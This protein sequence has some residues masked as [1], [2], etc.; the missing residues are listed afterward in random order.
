MNDLTTSE[1][2][3][4]FQPPQASTREPL[5][6][7]GMGC[8]FPG[9]SASPARFWENLLAGKDCIV[10]VP[11][12]RWDV[13]RFYDSD[14]EKPGK[15]YVKS[16][17]FLAENIFEF[18]A[19]FFGVSPR[20]AA[21]MDPQQRV[22]MEVSW[23]AL[24]DAGID[25]QSLAGSE[26]GV[27][28]GGFMLDNKL[29]QLSPLNRHTI[30]AST[31]VGMTL[32]MLS[33]RISYLY[34]LRGPSMTIDTA[35]SASM[36]ALDQA[37]HS[38]WNGNSKLALV[39]GVNL[40]HRP[41]I[42]VGLCK[43]GFLAPDGR[44]KAFDA[45]ANGYGRGEGAGMVVLKPLADA[46]RDGDRIYALIRAT[47]CNQDGRTDGITVPNPESQKALIRKVSARAGVP[48]KNIHYFEAHGTGT[49]VGDPLEMSAIGDTI[50]REKPASA[51]CIVGSVK[52]NIGHLEAASGVAGLI[53]TS[54]CL[55]HRVVPP[56]ANLQQLNP[57]IPFQDLRIKVPRRP[58]PLPAGGKTIYGGINSFGYG[59]TN[60]CAIL[61]SY[62]PQPQSV[63]A[64]RIE[65]PAG[66]QYLLPLSARSK[67]A[68]TALVDRY[69]QL[70]ETVTPDISA[71]CYSAGERR[72]HLSHRVCVRGADLAEL[73]SGLRQFREGEPGDLYVEGQVNQARDRLVFVFTGMGPQWW[74]MGRELLA[75]EPVFRAAVERCDR[76]FRPIAGWS[77]LEEMLKPEAE[78]RIGET[79]IAQ[80]ANF[81]LQMALVELLASWG[82]E[83]AA[84]VGHSVG[85]VTSAYCSGIL[86]LEQALLVSYHRSRVQKKAAH[87]GSML[88]VGVELAEALTLI[89]PFGG[90]VSIA[91][92]NAPTAI[93]LAGDTAALEA[94]AAQLE[95]RG[96]FNRMLKV[97]VAY[98]SPTMDPLL[99]ELRECLA[100]LETG[101][102]QL[103]VY[104]TVT[105]ERITD[106]AFDDEYWCRNVRQPVYFFKALEQLLADGYE[107]F[108][109][110]GPHPV[111]STAIKECFS[112]HQ[113]K[114]M[115]LSTLK[116]GAPEQ[117]T[118]KLAVAALHTHGYRLRW[119]ELCGSRF[120]W[121]EEESCCAALRPPYMDLPTYPW[122]REYHW[123]DAP[124]SRND[125]IGRPIAHAVLGAR[126]SGPGASWL[127]PVGAAYFPYVQDHQVED[128]VILPGA[129]YI[130]AALAAHQ[131]LSG[132]DACLLTD[133]RLHNA[134]VVDRDS[135]R[136]L[137][138]QVDTDGAFEIHSHTLA[139]CDEHT[140]H[141]TGR[142]QPL[143]LVYHRR[144]DL[145]AIKASGMQ[146]LQAPDIY[147]ELTA[148]GLQYGPK[149][150]GVQMLWRR[151][152]EVLACIRAHA[153]L[154]L[155]APEYQLHPTLLDACFQSLIS[156]LPES[157]GLSR[158]VYIPVGIGQLRHYRKAGAA[159]YCHGVIHEMDAQAIR[160]DMRICDEQGEVLVEILDLRCQA[161]RA[162]PDSARNLDDWAY[163][164]LWQPAASLLAA[165]G[166]CQI[167][168][169]NE[170]Q[171]AAMESAFASQPLLV[172]TPGSDYLE[173]GA[174]RYQLDSTDPE[175]LRNLLDTC[176]EYPAISL[177]Y[178]LAM[179]QDPEDP[180]HQLATSRLL[181]FLQAVHQLDVPVPVRIHVLTLDAQRVL[182]DD[183]AEGFAQS[184]AIGIVRVAA[185][186]LP[187][188]NCRT[189]DLDSALSPAALQQL[190][191]ECAAAP[192]SEQEIALRGGERFV[193]RL[194]HSSLAAAARPSVGL[195][196]A[197]GNFTLAPTPLA[198]L[199]G[200][201]WQVCHRPAPAEHEMEIEVLA[202]V[203]GEV[204]EVCARVVRVG[205]AV[206]GFAEGDQIMACYKGE[207]G[208][209]VVL[210]PARVLAVHK[211][212]SWPVARAAG[213]LAGLVLAQAALLEYGV[214]RSGRSVLVLGSDSAAGQSL[215]ALAA[216]LRSPCVAVAAGDGPL[217][218]NSATL[219]DEVLAQMPQRGFDLIVTTCGP[220]PHLVT[221][222]LLAPGG[223]YL[224]LDEQGGP[225][226][227]PVQL[228]AGKLQ[229][230]LT[231]AAVL[232][233]TLAQPC[234]RQ[235]RM[236]SLIS[237]LE[238]DAIVLPPLE[239]R[240]L[241]QNAQPGVV[242]L[243]GSATPVIGRASASLRIRPD[244]TY[245]ITGGFGGF[246]LGTA[247]WLVDQGARH[248]VLAS[249][250][251]GQG[252]G[253]VLA[254]LEAAGA[255]VYPA[256][257]DMADGAAVQSLLAHVAQEMPP[258]AGIFHTAGV[259]DDRELLTVD[260]ASLAKVMA[261]KALGAWHL[262][263][264]TRHLDLD[265]FVLY[266]S[267]SA[268]IGNR[269]QANYVAANLFL[270][271]LA[272]Y[273]QALGLAATSIN[274]GA[275]SDAGMAAETNV[276]QH[277]EQLGIRGITLQQALKSMAAIMQAPVA[278]FGLFDIDWQRWSRFEPASAAPRFAELV[279]SVQAEADSDRW[280]ALR[281]QGVEVLAA[282]V[283]Q[284]FAAMLGA[285]L[286][287]AV[288]HIDPETPINRYGLDSLMAI[289][290]QMKIREE[291]R[292]D[293]SI[294]ELMKGNSLNR[295]AAIVADRMPVSSSSEETAA[296][297]E[298]SALQQPATSSPQ[299]NVEKLDELSEEELDAL[300][301][302][303][304]ELS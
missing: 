213:A 41:E 160:G 274:W 198:R 47:G 84:I 176:R 74:G 174:G 136:L 222:K 234:G 16:G 301:S 156:A 267:V 302:R 173:T 259:L 125:R 263:N 230:H 269:N 21:A 71:L 152:G 127:N 57:K 60:A 116:R 210:D 159:L 81:V 9:A 28:I 273:R 270:D 139:H 151:D 239:A 72:G 131:E 138:T 104:S 195:A 303:E 277:L 245:L 64:G 87:Q 66:R 15:M 226:P 133:I 154:S 197:E 285:T 90:A 161:L 166:A 217:Q 192:G 50:G 187:R 231:K 14:R 59:G 212:A 200:T 99:D 62:Q 36:V 260:S 168:F 30:S 112:R 143:P 271:N 141:A 247:R 18:D 45:R 253:E 67:P 7:I 40:M 268:L 63:P 201:P 272:Q 128:L 146:V 249:R 113:V 199:L 22:L 171:G 155:P 167:L 80:P 42:F 218:L 110:V 23:E 283:A 102:P 286:K 130:E 46:E 24:E 254:E 95:A 295:I 293:I 264:L 248:L 256:A 52:G 144:L 32:T 194:C 172:V 221:D 79:Q 20:E 107:D 241:L 178:A 1:L 165:D 8:R 299:V 175:Q 4:V 290:L 240:A 140:L 202:L 101:A 118:L 252:A 278:Q 191:A 266:S 220:V 56:Q 291:F 235:L 19:L 115:L 73:A 121:D 265:C 296:G 70:L 68:L 25:P 126:E 97:E 100:D 108:L 27:F 169:V 276:I 114:G 196:P 185:V 129:A 117:P 203:P 10:D 132:S 208:R 190:A 189:I 31:A 238:C 111:L 142:I 109:E 237:T 164:G 123:N 5:A 148:R 58:T 34:D 289:D 280:S 225:A 85:E 96:A 153:N 157:G 304:L 193:Y 262:H 204:R 82:I 86:S 134:L 44:S 216:G 76:V 281:A 223:I 181:A 51:P 246:G 149:F 183:R 214:A 163:Q 17:G 88:A 2:I 49:A 135:E 158:Q 177:V 170:E 137:Q 298:T 275:I 243:E 55:H 244:A 292:V 257:V 124:Q 69:L 120:V 61:Q 250:S 39:G 227:A 150:Q 219:M 13:N 179:E 186:E 182:P 78:S 205:A 188:L 229:L 297:T 251:G 29:T 26:T 12:D 33:N 38:L 119:A 284:N 37:C 35:C 207:I 215:A 209:Y 98:H 288:E 180:A 106:T 65:A 92:I 11:A 77:I 147:A 211:P 94:I 48:L 242:V 206:R 258:L 83:P 91:A 105:G 287:L 54:L 122:Q 236:E 103:P 255:K 224:A 43:G 6:I 162:S 300:L 233:D 3:S 261:P 89:A 228:S 232:E 75:S 145:I 53:K 184:P 93:T 279:E 294:L 282:A